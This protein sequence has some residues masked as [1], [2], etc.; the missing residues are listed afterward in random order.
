MEGLV[1]GD[2]EAI[3]VVVGVEDR[4]HKSNEPGP[5]FVASDWLVGIFQLVRT[6]FAVQLWPSSLLVDIVRHLYSVWSQNIRTLHSEE[7]YPVR[8]GAT[9]LRA[10]NQ[11]FSALVLSPLSRLERG[12]LGSKR[13]LAPT[14]PQGDRRLAHHGK[15]F[16]TRVRAKMIRLGRLENQ[17]E[18]EMP[19][20][21]VQPQ[22]DSLGSVR[23]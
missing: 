12:A 17:R 7:W 23:R 8:T 18:K 9:R 4:G 14:H 6:L 1:V 16:N 2:V 15:A 21:S 19:A 20:G 3:V 10:S 13:P 5:V 11:A 22:G